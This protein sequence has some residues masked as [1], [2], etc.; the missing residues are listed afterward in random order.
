LSELEFQ[1]LR[2]ELARLTRLLLHLLRRLEK[3]TDTVRQSLE[4][5]ILLKAGQTRLGV[6]RVLQYPEGT[7]ID[8]RKIRALTSN[9]IVTVEQSDETKLKATTIQTEPGT[10]TFFSVSVTAAGSQSVL[11]P[12]SGKKLK[13]LAWN[14]YVD[15]DVKCLLR[16]A[17]SGNIIAGIP[18]KGINA[19]NLI[20]RACPTGVADESV[21]I[22][23]SGAA[24]AE[25][26]ICYEEVS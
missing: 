13:I 10:I 1:R 6:R 26:W 22:Y 16:F 8:P 9:D 4:K 21:E 5:P 11:T 3:Q 2:D 20:H 7:D 23:L 18:T 12:S 17:T 24:T 15:S 14:F 25:G 19:M